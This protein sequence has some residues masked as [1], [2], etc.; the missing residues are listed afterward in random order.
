MFITNLIR[1]F[2]SWQRYRVGVR[3][4]SAMDERGLNDIGLD[5]NMNLCR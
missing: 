1:V 4:L 5:R 3:E 2:A